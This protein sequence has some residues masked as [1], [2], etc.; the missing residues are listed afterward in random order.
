M[1]TQWTSAYDDLLCDQVKSK[2][3]HPF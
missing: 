1:A 2:T 3:W